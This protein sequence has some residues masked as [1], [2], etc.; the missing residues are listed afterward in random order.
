[1]TL[2]FGLE[3]YLVEGKKD[4]H[5]QANLHVIR[6]WREILEVACRKVHRAFLRITVQSVPQQL[7]P[8]TSLG[9]RS[10]SQQ[11]KRNIQTRK[12]KVKTKIGYDSNR[13]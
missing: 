7:A 10:T 8:S 3:S 6:Y 13:L 12:E 11:Y 4:W 5:L 1:L 2:S 9:A